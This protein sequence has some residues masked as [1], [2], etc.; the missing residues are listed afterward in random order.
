MILCAFIVVAWITGSWLWIIPKSVSNIDHILIWFVISICIIN[1][2]TLLSLNLKW[3]QITM[4]PDKYIAYLIDRSLITP[5]LLLI[6]VNILYTAKNL[7]Y[8]IT[9]ILYIVILWSSGEIASILTDVVRY[10]SWNFLYA[11][12]IFVFYFLLSYGL[13]QI[14]QR[15]SGVPQS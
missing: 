1:I 6:F 2:N 8:K 7:L 12:G 9:R 11:L 3:I 13:A 5:L 4:E 14:L 10:R 15:K